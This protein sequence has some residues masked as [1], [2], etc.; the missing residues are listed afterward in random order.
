MEAENTTF[1]KTKSIGAHV[2]YRYHHLQCGLSGLAV[3]EHSPCLLQ[4]SSYIWILSFSVNF[5]LTMAIFFS[6]L[7]K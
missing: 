2:F 7:L 6:F 4:V 3:L 5:P 1:H